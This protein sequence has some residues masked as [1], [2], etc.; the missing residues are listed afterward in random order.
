MKPKQRF[1]VNQNDISPRNI[2]SNFLKLKAVTKMAK[3]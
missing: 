2:K 3:G 1:N